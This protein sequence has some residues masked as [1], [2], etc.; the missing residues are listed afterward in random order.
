MEIYHITRNIKV[1]G[2]VVENFPKGV[3]E[4]FQELIEKIPNG[5]GRVYYGISWCIGNDITYIA[6]AEQKSEDEPAK[7]NCDSYTIEKGDYLCIAVDNWQSKVDCIKD[8]FAEIMK[9]ERADNKTPAIEIYK[10]DKELLC[11]I[12]AKR[13]LETLDEFADTYKAFLNAAKSFDEE[14]INQV[15]FENSWTAAQVLIHV[16]KSNYGIAKAMKLEGTK[17]DRDTDSRVDELRK[18]FLDYT[19]KFKSPEFIIPPDGAQDRNK[20]IEDFERSVEQIKEAGKTA[21]LTE[22]IKHVAFGEITKLELLHFVLF[23]MQRHTRQ[24]RNILSHIKSE[25]FSN[26]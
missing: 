26:N 7:Y 9:D 10:N 14:E 1:F 22:A 2:S 15:P 11:M 8:F 16:T 20:I 19:V 25:Q 3:G 23:H 12:A 13:S 24:L 4:A 6:A 17:V 21:N 5:H 18:T